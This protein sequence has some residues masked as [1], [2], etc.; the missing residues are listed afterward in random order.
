MPGQRGAKLVILLPERRRFGRVQ[1]GAEV[2]RLLAR[3]DRLGDGGAGEQAQ[4]SRYFETIPK[5]WP[6]AA[7]QRQADC[8]DASGFR[9]LRAD[10]VY[11]RP[12]ISGAR[13]MAWGNLGLDADDAETLL[14]ALRP[15]FGDAGLP[16]TMGAPERWYLQ[17]A[18]DAPLPEFSPPEQGLGDDLFRHLP[19][20][21]Q[22]KRWRALLNESQIVLH[23]HPFNAARVARGHSPVNSLWFWG[24]GVLPERVSTDI[25]GVTSTETDVLALAARAAIATDDADHGSDLLDLRRERDWRKIESRLSG[26]SLSETFAGYGE[27]VLDFADGARWRVR[28]RQRWRFW[29]RAVG[30]L[31]A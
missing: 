9:W 6:M 27:I 28:Q 25:A 23:N 10:P 26:A 2:A 18:I 21:G 12:D 30:D 5:G 4:L 31:G 11:V 14:Q 15:V 20:G 29:R 8:A 16:L 22:G 3:A 1:L 24:A 13:L 7:L 17:L 19:E